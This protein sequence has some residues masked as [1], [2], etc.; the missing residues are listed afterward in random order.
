MTKYKPL[1]HIASTDDKSWNIGIRKDRLDEYRR[2]SEEKLT[3]KDKVN[4]ILS[5]MNDNT[6]SVESRELF[7]KILGDHQILNKLIFVRDGSY[8]N[9]RI[10][11]KN[12]QLSPNYEMLTEISLDDNSRFDP[13][14]NQLP[15]FSGKMGLNYMKNHYESIFIQLTTD[16][17][18]CYE[19]YFDTLSR[20]ITCR[21]PKIGSS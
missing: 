11:Y 9:N 19:K 15:Q 4:R 18:V 2:Y 5:F 13:V 3:R 14:R 21:S 6:I 7:N 20:P 16:D 12:F 1:F 8:R 17:E 10:F